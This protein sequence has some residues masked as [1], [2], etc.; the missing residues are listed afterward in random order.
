MASSGTYAYAPSNADIVVGAFGR[1]QV[2]PTSITTEQMQRAQMQANLLMV[3]INS[4]QPNLWISENQDI[5]LLDGTAT[6]TLPVYT[7]MITTAVVRTNDGETDQNDRLITP[8]STSDYWS[9]PNKL[10]EGPPNIYWFDR[11][12][13]P[14]ITFWPVPDADD[15][16][17]V[18]AQYLRQLQ[19]I[20]LPGGETPNLPNRFF[21]VFEAGLAYRLS[22]F[23]APQLEQ[24]RKADY[25]EAWQ[26]AATGDVENT[27][28]YLTP[29]LS[30]YRT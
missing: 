30:G 3:E 15:T 14:Q 2:R 28:L 22:R 23:Y 7:V 9:Y 11:Q 17:I 13:I 1:I 26:V 20:G 16:Y 5:T 8:V 19:D 25:M 27:P 24:T 21:D 12:I 18:K 4:R 10:Q 29:Q 6:Y